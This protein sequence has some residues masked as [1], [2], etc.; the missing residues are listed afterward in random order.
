MPALE[1][2]HGQYY[3]HFEQLVNQGDLYVFTPNRGLAGRAHSFLALLWDKTMDD[4]GLELP[5]N[6][7]QKFV[8]VPGTLND[9]TLVFE[10][11]LAP[12]C[13]SR[14]R[15]ARFDSFAASSSVPARPQRTRS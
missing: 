12:A 7:P 11:L 2:L 1:L 5:L 3:A 10:V 13:L 15:S 6:L 8:R 9:K 4:M 14:A